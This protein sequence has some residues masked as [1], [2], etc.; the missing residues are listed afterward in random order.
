M[1]DNTENKTIK[2]SPNA[3]RQAQKSAG[4]APGN[5]KEDKDSAMRGPKRIGLFIFFLV[6]GVF[7]V[8][9]VVAPLDGAANAPGTVVSRSNKKVIQHLEGG[10]V[11][12][13]LAQNGDIVSAGE[14]LLTL[15][16]TQPLAE[17]E[18]ANAQYVSFKALEA[19]LIAERDGLEAVAYPAS[20]SAIASDSLVEIEAQNQIFRARRNALQG[21]VAVLEQ[22]GQQLQ[23]RLSGMRAL[24]DV[25]EELSAS[26]AEE[27]GEVRELLAEG[28]SDKNRLRELER[29]ESRLRGEA[30]ELTASISS[31]EMQVGETQLEILQQERE[32][33]NEVVTE[34]SETKTSLRDITERM[35]GLRDVVTRTIITAPEDGIVNGLQVHT[36][37]G[38]IRSGT[39]I[40]EIIPLADELIIEVRVAPMDID[41]VDVGQDASIRFSS[42]SSSVPTIDGRVIHIS[43]DAFTDE[44]TGATYYTARTVVTPEGMAELNNLVLVPGMPAEVFINTGSR[45]FIQYLMKPISNALARSFIED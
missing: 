37:G 29:N 34:L 36:I 28:F 26:Y 8:W 31:T 44:Q 4:Q 2:P 33:Q 13:I 32:F 14:T 43:A 40:A 17:L 20:L 11:S 6:F 16:N 41:R 21:T 9:A 45:T 1:A 25:K 7:G 19:R 24:R 15:D 35:R 5:S 38:V 39:T 30:A 18:V 27:L 12:E 42:F 23:S 3:G 10:I 22:R